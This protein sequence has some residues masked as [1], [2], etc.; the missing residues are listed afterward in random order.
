MKN[1]VMYVGIAHETASVSERAH[2]AL[3]DGQK[4]QFIARLKRELSLKGVVVLSTCNRT[5][6]YFE[7]YGATPDLVRDALMD[8][9]KPGHLVNL[10]RSVFKM[11]DDTRET[12][13]H[14]LKVSNGLKSAIIGDKQ[15]ITQIKGA[16][17]EALKNRD[18]GS[19]LERAF[20]SVFKSHKRIS[21]ESLYQNGSTSAA[22][23]S[24]K[25]V[26][27][28]LAKRP[29]S[30]N[31]LLLIGAGQITQDILKYLGKFGLTNVFI[32]NRTAEKAIK[33][34]EQ[35]ALGIYDWNRVLQND[36]SS[37]DAII[38]A[39][40]NQKHLVRSIKKYDKKRIWIDLAMPSNI[41][42]AISNPFNTIYNI[43]EISKKIDMANQDHLRAIPVV[44]AI[45]E[46][47]L[48][49]FMSWA[50]RNATCYIFHVD[51]KMHGSQT[52]I[53]STTIKGAGE[54]Y[55]AS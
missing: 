51:K 43:D 20:Q 29:L 35:Y 22:Y 24:I 32:A 46:E 4:A 30:Q 21:R 5:E 12:V 2:Y 48:D 15:I 17:Q 25:M 23:L 53:A 31:K 13:H 33:L 40:G 36:L 8:F 45:I 10:K 11:F 16:Y 54:I 44:E 27:Q 41:D 37:F 28:F 39:V 3:N 6:I 50:N 52:V 49:A 47:E 19:L 55:L 9:V 42:K 38:S 18:Q 1:R 14:L 7:S 26:K 34:A